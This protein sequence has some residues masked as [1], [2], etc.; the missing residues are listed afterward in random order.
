MKRH[1]S[2][3]YILSANNH[4]YKDTTIGDKLF[5]GKETYITNIRLVKLSNISCKS[6]PFVAC[7]YCGDKQGLQIYLAPLPLSSEWLITH[8]F[9]IM[10]L[11]QG[12][13]KGEELYN[14]HLNH[15]EAPPPPLS[16][17]KFPKTLVGLKGE[18]I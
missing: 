8:S 15:L 14:T 4:G 1:M 9:L 5:L 7:S 12:C 11:T 13:A 17:P 3:T 16:N 2:P 6:L 10:V 18:C